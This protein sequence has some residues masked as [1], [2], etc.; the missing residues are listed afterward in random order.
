MSRSPSRCSRQPRYP[1]VN[2]WTA[3][4]PD[5][6]PADPGTRYHHT[7]APVR[8]RRGRDT[9][10]VMVLPGGEIDADIIAMLSPFATLHDG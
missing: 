6:D 1:Q 2:Y 8:V 5:P 7:A 10:I 4:S 9:L 3:S